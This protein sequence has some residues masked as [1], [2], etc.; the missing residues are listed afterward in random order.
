MLEIYMWKQIQ[1]LKIIGIKDPH[2][3]DLAYYKISSKTG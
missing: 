2:E 1:N 3:G